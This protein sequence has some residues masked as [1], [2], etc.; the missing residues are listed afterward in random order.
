MIADYLMPCYFFDALFILSF[1]LEV[2]V[3]REGSPFDKLLFISYFIRYYAGD[4]I[5]F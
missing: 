2:I 5:L 1:L 3:F 4:I